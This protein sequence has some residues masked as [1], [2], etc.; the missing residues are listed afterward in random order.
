[1]GAVKNKKNI[2]PPP[3]PPLSRIHGEGD[4]KICVVCGSGIVMGGF[5]WLTPLGCRQPKC[6]NYY[7]KIK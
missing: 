6:K 4:T 2:P 5:L 7:K 1:M 3:P